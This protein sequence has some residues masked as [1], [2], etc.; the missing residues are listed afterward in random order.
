MVLAEAGEARRRQPHPVQPLLVQPVRGCLHR[1]MGDAG[2]GH[3]GDVA[4]QRD[5]VGG[6]VRQGGL[7]GAFDPGGAEVRRLPAH[8][9]PDLPREGRDR[10]LAVGAGHRDH[11]FRLAAEPQG[12][13][14][15]QRLPRILG[16]D[17]G[18]GGLGQRGLGQLRAFAVGQDRA[19]A[20]LQRRR[21]IFGA[22]G[23]AARQRREQMPG[24]HAAAVD[25]QPRDPRLAAALGMQPQF[26]QRPRRLIRI[27]TLP[28]SRGS[29]LRVPHPRRRFQPRAVCPEA[30]RPAG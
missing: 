4:V 12:G 1:Q 25:A 20:L 8:Q 10:G 13:G 3:G 24:A 23:L 7:I 18:H 22:M 30:A 28:L 2:L 19:R 21:E 27:H 9:R 11:G 15:G 17:Q 16:D 5:R 6:G 26:G 29:P 14:I